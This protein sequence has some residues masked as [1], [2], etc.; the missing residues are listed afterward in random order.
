MG[1]VVALIVIV[2]GGLLIAMQ[3]RISKLEYRLRLAED[4]LRGWIAAGGVPE[5][6]KNASDA[7]PA[8]K[9]SRQPDVKTAP[10]PPLG[11]EWYTTPDPEPKP[12]PKA[13]P[14]PETITT[15]K[16]APVDNVTPQAQDEQNPKVEPAPLPAAAPI[17]PATR[18]V[19]SPVDKPERPEIAAQSIASEEF[20][21]AEESLP[22]PPAR[23][24][25]INFEELFGR[26]LPI[27]A[28][29]I[30][31]A[32]AGILIVRYA[33]D[34]GFFE[35]IFTPGVQVICGMVFGLGLIG[36]AEW[37][38]RR[39]EAVDD[40]R[41]SQALSGAGIS[42]LYASLLV[43]TNLYHLIS[44]LT[45][46]FGLALVTA[47]A[48]WLSLRH[49]VPSAILG[50]AGGLA[51]PALTVGLDANVPMLAVYLAFT[52]AGIVGVSRIQRWPWLALM[53]LL[54]GAGWSLWLILA[55]Q[56]LTTLGALSVGGF[57][58]M[59]AI[60]APLF[61]FRDAR[62][63]LWRAVSATVGAVQLALL[64]ATGGYQPLYWGLFILIAFAGQCIAWREKGFAIVPTIGAAL[65]FLLLMLWPHPAGGWLATFALTLAAIYAL[66]LL[67][68]LW[69]I[70]AVKQRTVELCA[71]AAAAPIIALRHFP[72]PWGTTDL[73]AA[74]TAM[75]GTLLVLA[76]AFI[77]WK[78]A[79]RHDDGRFALLLT[80]AGGLF[81][82]AAWFAMPHWQAPLWIAAVAAAL[83]L[84]SR[85]A[86][87][88]RIEPLAAIYS[89]L[90]LFMLGLT[91][92]TRL[93]EAAI[94]IGL[95]TAPTDGASLL[96][97]SGMTAMFVLF[98]WRA[99]EFAF[100]LYG[101]MLAT[102]MAYGVL[103][104]LLPQWSLPLAMAIVTAVALFGM[105]R[106]RDNP[107][108]EGKLTIFA[109]A[110]VLLLAITGA[111][112]LG[113]WLRL[114]DAGDAPTDVL[115]LLR[116]G[117]VG[118]LGAFF[119][120]RSRLQW[121]RSLGQFAALL[122]AYGALAQVVPGWTL[123]IV[124]AAIASAAFLVLKRQA[125]TLSEWQVLALMAGA[126]ALLA[127]SGSDPAAEY[128]RVIG[129]GDGPLNGVACAR[130]AA[131]AAL[132]VLLATR[133][134]QD[135]VREIGQAIAALL[136]YGA[137]AQIM[138]TV[139]L[140]VIIPAIC[141]GLSWWSRSLEWPRLR[142]AT[143]LLAII[144]VLWASF[145]L[146]WWASEAARSLVGIPM[147]LA[148]ADLQPFVVIRRLLIPGLLLGACLWLLRDQLARRA[149]LL[150]AGGIGL[151][152]CVALHSLYRAAFAAAFGNDFVATGLSERL[153][154]CVL[155][156][157]TGY[158]LWKRSVGT[159]KSRLAPAL[160][161]MAGLHIGWYSLLLHNP[162]WTAQAVGPLPVIN[163]LIPLF[164]ALP[165]CVMLIARMLPDRAGILDRALQPL[166]MVMVA[167][168]AWASLRQIF[169]GA[170]LIEPGLS[171]TED[172]LRSIIGIVLAI[173]YLLWGIRK[174]R[175]DW[176]IASLMLMLAA[177]AK[178][179]LFDARGLE[180]LLRI[181]SFVALG[182]SLIGIGW[183]YSRQLRRSESSTL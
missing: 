92:V 100:R 47:A 7:P 58:L 127:I 83:L 67:M 15:E 10:R 54:G 66:P 179:F 46:F 105:Q 34:A 114:V 176:R 158:A 50:L 88:I 61:A 119:A 172:I 120:W 154:W 80:V 38:H 157:G 118:L 99:K 131:I 106:R 178:V 117:G 73:L 37:A 108:T 87:D 82:I 78:S 41:V 149:T 84:V 68:R 140:P 29:G 170:L 115:A 145:P 32:I 141:L 8:P 98:A 44:P 4:E 62:A 116:W 22:P 125:S 59:L 135:A 153:L 31:L 144:S 65:S 21:Q 85:P 28:G 52:I 160:I 133:G 33:I 111:H 16:P 101:W 53:A 97:W 103:A 5:W 9:V 11:A 124:M 128:L 107:A 122:L 51:A 71:I 18:I 24:A 76:G 43:A 150:L 156:A 168:L 49:G 89:A 181:A 91:T 1:F 180:G 69:R 183:L 17:I 19:S 164:A 134:R 36:G 165:L 143:T 86:A 23:R 129:M 30:T 93:N 126:I 57:V 121:L 161:I 64:V 123:P 74:L 40:P 56:A 159:L 75:G 182:F 147:Q 25:A 96:R 102:L 81:S 166:L 132:G 12:K 42:T 35:R 14:A 77:G 95:P 110:S 146:L 138:P 155:L 60:A 163:L 139:A 26:K 173:G 174:N 3:S 39:R 171:Q 2:G 63:I 79:D 175:H 27:W 55:G 152:G 113:E 142:T 112:P 104:Q 169:H 13:A 94:L 72:A 167:M 177:V 6:R 130:W 48:L 70:P 109:A 137:L 148:A 136:G 90:A 162:L 20:T 151:L 45:A